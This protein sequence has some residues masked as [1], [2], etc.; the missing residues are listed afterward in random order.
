MN[1]SISLNEIGKKI[2]FHIDFDYFY[3]QCEEIR[4]PELRDIPSVVC[5]YSGRKDDS[6][7]VSTCNY[8]ARKYGVKAAMPIKVAKSKLK[9]VGAVFL[10]TD[11]PYYQETSR[12]AMKI[13]QNYGDLFEQV[14]VDECYVDFTKI[15]NSDFDD[16]KI[17][18]TSLQKNIKEQINLTCSIG[19][20]PNKLISKIASGVN[21]PNGITVVSQ[22]DAKNFIS[23]CKIE[24]IPGVGP[25]TALKLN[26]LGI[27]SISD[28]SKKNIFELRDA[29]GYKTAT[30]LAN[31]SNAID[32][33]Q[34]KIR[35][36][37]KQIG[38]IVTLKKDKPEFEQIKMIGA[39]LCAS[40]FEN[41]K[42]KR[43]AFKVLTVIL[44]LENLQ[45]VS[46]SKSLKLYSA[47]LEELNKNSLLII[48]EMITNNSIS[49]DN[50][51]R[52]GVIV[53][54]LKDIS[55]QDSLLNYFEN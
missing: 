20:G 27:K 34:I 4:K 41:L 44:I 8:E 48:N 19:V 5:V 32:Y 12:N 43:Q 33:S 26:S 55:G 28:I 47:S 22:D 35:G 3:A 11:I 10:P 51:R 52:M 24:D 40:V 15:T 38:K 14:S 42:N 7:V 45:H 54:D 29:L 6:G 49:L 13:I 23:N 2:I 50:I 39:T 30:F 53:S 31:A 21:K 1:N 18:A 17:F 36:T 25:K 37:S 9:D 16:A 46:I